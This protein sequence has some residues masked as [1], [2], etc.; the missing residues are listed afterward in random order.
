MGKNDSESS[1]GLKGLTT[2]RCSLNNK[3]MRK[4]DID[5][6]YSIKVLYY[7]KGLKQF[8]S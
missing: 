1:K 7:S 2:K 6:C 8:I 4:K 5:D 3:K